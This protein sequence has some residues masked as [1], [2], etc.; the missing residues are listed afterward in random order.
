MSVT[1]RLHQRFADGVAE[2]CGGI[3]TSCR[4]F[5]E[6]LKNRGREMLRDIRSAV[7]DG[8][9]LLGQNLLQSDVHAVVE[10]VRVF[11]GQQPV[12]RGRRKVLAS[13]AASAPRLC[14]ETQRTHRGADAAPLA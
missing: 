8:D 9:R 13:G 14:D 3:E 4:I 1:L 10:V 2:F 11:L 7:A 6:R 5:T 12:Q